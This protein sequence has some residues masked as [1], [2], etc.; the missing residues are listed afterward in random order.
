MSDE[1][2][3]SVERVGVTYSWHADRFVRANGRL[4]G[5]ISG[6]ALWWY[7]VAASAAGTQYDPPS[8]DGFASAEAA[9]AAMAQELGARLPHSRGASAGEQHG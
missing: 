7:Q 2:L 6:Y 8:V 4:V 9:L 3:L 1:A 5:R